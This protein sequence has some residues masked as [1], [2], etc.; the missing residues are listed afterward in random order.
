[1]KQTDTSNQ[2]A[3]HYAINNPTI[4]DSYSKILITAGVD[5]M[6]VDNKG[7][8]PMM[9]YAKS[10]RALTYDVVSHLSSGV[11]IDRINHASREKA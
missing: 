9:C 4:P 10:N 6:K 1:M 7:Y 2:N 11:A 8:N 3:L 5:F